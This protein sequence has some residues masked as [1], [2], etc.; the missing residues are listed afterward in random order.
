MPDSETLSNGEAWF[1]GIGFIASA[2]ILIGLG[3]S[4]TNRQEQRINRPDFLSPPPNYSPP[5]ETFDTD[6]N[7]VL[8]IKEY[9]TLR[10]GYNIIRR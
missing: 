4:Q 1:N 8:D 9:E 5:F 2:A 10:K 7:R 6:G 3:V